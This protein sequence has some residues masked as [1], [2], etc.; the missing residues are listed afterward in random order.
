MV[1]A[2]ACLLWYDGARASAEFDR[3]VPA[4][5]TNNDYY[6]ASKA[7]IL[8]G[9]GGDASTVRELT[10]SLLNH[11][12][13]YL[14]Y[15]VLLAL[16]RVSAPDEVKGYANRALKVSRAL[17]KESE[18]MHGVDPCI[19]FLAGEVTEEKLLDD[20]KGHGFAIA[21]AHTTIAMLQFAEGN[22]EA[23][24]D[25]LRKAVDTQT[26]NSFN[27]EWARACLAQLDDGQDP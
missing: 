8:A 2:C 27:Y 18:G 21:A 24:R 4:S 12:S 9:T 1:F 14:R 15:N 11:P 7:L 16:S 20:A 10:E 6:R 3:V 26:V 19:E 23:A 22:L 17:V 25:H 13:T 5:D